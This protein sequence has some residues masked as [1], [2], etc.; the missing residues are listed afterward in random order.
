MGLRQFQLEA[1]TLARLHHVGIAQIFEAGHTILGSQEQ[2]FIAMEYVQ[3]RNISN[4]Q[5]AA[6][7]TS[8]KIDLLIKVYQAVE[9]AHQNG[10]L[11]RDLKPGNILVS[12]A[13][14]PKILDFGLARRS[15]VATP[16]CQGRRRRA[17]SWEHS[18]T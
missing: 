9:H 5:V 3:G 16:S 13:G 4:K 6:C 1:E 8:T 2:P 10:V 12:A 7:S 11:H 14:E 15:S 18:P 17:R